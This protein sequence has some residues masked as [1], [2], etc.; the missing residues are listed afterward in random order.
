MIE[1]VADLWAVDC[2]AR[3]ITTNGTIKAN[4]RGVMG[5]GCAK[6]AKTRL[7]GLEITLGAQLAQHG[8]HV[9]VLSHT[10]TTSAPIP[11]VM[12]PVKHEWHQRADVDLIEQ[13]AWELVNLATAKGWQRVVL[14]RPGCGNGGLNWPDNVRHLLLPILD[15]RFLVVTK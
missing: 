7:L 9:A 11:L 4:G 5:R 3:C 10:G 6:E 14:P 15:D 8:N 13:S 1:A 2:H 12:F